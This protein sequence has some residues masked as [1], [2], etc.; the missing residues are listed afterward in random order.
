MAKGIEINGMLRGKRGGVVYSRTNGQQVSRA[1]NFNPANPRTPSQLYQRAI[2]A[3]VMRAYSAGKEIFDHS[4]Q[5]KK[6]P[7]GNQTYFQSKNAKLLRQML[8]SDLAGTTQLTFKGVGPGTLTPV[9]GLYYVSEGSLNQNFFVIT[10]ASETVATAKVGTPAVSGTET[11]A[12]Y[13]S[14]N[15]LNVGD[16]YTFVCFG[17]NFSDENAFV[18]QDG[19]GQ[20]SVQPLGRFCWCRLIV[21]QPTT[22][23]AAAE[24]SSCD[25]SDFLHVDETS[26]ISSVELMGKAPG[27]EDEISDLIEFDDNNYEVS[28]FAIIRSE[29]NSGL[30]ST[31]QMQYARYS[32]PEGLDAANIL[33]GW[34]Q[35]TPRVG[36]S[37]L[38]LEGAGF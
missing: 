6:V 25:L 17:L 30:R 29:D 3:T 32:H 31:E 26:N 22:E 4:F 1:R 20:G 8:A 27:E 38:I 11:L 21:K 35:G 16:I 5:G 7:M 9:D 15:N 24:A 12:Q 37:D 34:Q 36:D 2:M 14:R 19:T 28:S 18:V 23:K 13:M 10:P 33:L